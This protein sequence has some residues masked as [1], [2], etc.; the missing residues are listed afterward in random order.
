M[1]ALRRA[2]L[3]ALVLACACGGDDSAERAAPEDAPASAPVLPTPPPRPPLTITPREGPGGTE[4]TLTLGG[5]MMNQP[6]LEIGF[7]DLTQHEIIGHASAD[8]DGNLSTVIAVPASA[9]PGTHYFFVAEEN[10]S[11]IAVSDS[12][13]VTSSGP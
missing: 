2:A 13:V 10:G 3:C 8:V 4:V 1:S 12:F 11:P 9:R 6:N 5:L 7:G